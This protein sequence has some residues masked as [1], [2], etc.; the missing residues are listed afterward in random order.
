MRVRGGAVLLDGFVLCGN[1]RLRDAEV[2]DHRRCHAN[3]PGAPYA[4]AW[5][6]GEQH[7]VGLDVAVHDAVLMR[8]REREIGRASC[9]ERVQRAV[10]AVL[11]CM[12]DTTMKI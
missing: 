12:S 9:R 1:E 6:A 4:I 11:L 5:S 10:V 3:V 2:G 7:V 8:I